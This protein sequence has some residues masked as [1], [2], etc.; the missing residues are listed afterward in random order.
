MAE[1]SIRKR[2]AALPWRSATACPPPA[3]WIP[4][5]PPRNLAGS[6]GGTR[7]LTACVSG[8]PAALFPSL[9]SSS[10]FQLPGGSIRVDT[11]TRA[12][13]EQYS[14]EYLWKAWTFQAEAYFSD[15]YS[16]S[17][18]PDTHLFTWYGSA[19]YRFNK[20]FEAGGYYT[21]YY[22][23]LDQSDNSLMS[24]KKTPRSPCGSMPPL[25]G[26]SKSKAITSVAPGC[27]R[28]RQAIRRRMAMAGGCLT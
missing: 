24:I 23:D 13:F 26:P 17:A 9:I 12:A 25:G 7:R 16:E 27:Y 22:G 14:A 15:Y 28:T 3:V 4:L 5:I 18:A 2:M 19:A 20:W 8:L 10:H 21:E 1:W 11:R 6:C